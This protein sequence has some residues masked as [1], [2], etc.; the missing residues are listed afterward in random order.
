M[1]NAPASSTNKPYSNLV[2]A[3]LQ[4]ECQAERLEQRSDERIGFN[5]PVAIRVEQGR[6]AI[7]GFTK[8]LSAEGMGIV[9]DTMLSEGTRASLR[10]HTLN[11]EIVCFPA[12]LVWIAAFGHGWFISGWKFVNET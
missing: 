7:S 5:R 2:E 3:L 1:M 9:L 4:E 8:N 12:Q 6:C 10:V 11:D